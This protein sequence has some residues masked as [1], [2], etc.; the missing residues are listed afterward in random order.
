MAFASVKLVGN[1]V[2]VAVNEFIA[3]VRNHVTIDIDGVVRAVATIVRIGHPIVI[4]I[5]QNIAGVW[6]PVLVLINGVVK[7][8]ARVLAVRNTIAI[9]VDEVV[10]GIRDVVVVL[11]HAVVSRRTAIHRVDRSIT[12]AVVDAPVTV[13]VPS[14][15]G[16]GGA[17]I[18]P[19][20]EVV[21]G[22]QCPIFQGWM[23][24]RNVMS[25]VDLIGRGACSRARRDGNKL[26]VNGS[27]STDGVHV[28]PDHLSVLVD[29]KQRSVRAVRDQHVTVRECINA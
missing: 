25:F 9:A 8:G 17:S 16:L 23:V 11:V 5:H 6:N 12:V 10:A 2:V 7:V 18:L 4:T 22:V 13:R 20:F 1:A 21:G 14:P 29:F 3:T 19:R 15:S 28:M 24:G 26:L 27:I